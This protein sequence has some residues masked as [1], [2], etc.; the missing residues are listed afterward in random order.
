LE[1]EAKALTRGAADAA[2]VATWCCWTALLWGGSDEKAVEDRKN[3]A[4]RKMHRRFV[5]MVK[6]LVL[7][8]FLARGNEYRINTLVVGPYYDGM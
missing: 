4:T 3:R 8:L 2:A 6:I 5:F 1:R 7:T